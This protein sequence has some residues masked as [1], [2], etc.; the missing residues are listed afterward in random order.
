MILFLFLT[1]LS[2]C[3][4]GVKFVWRPHLSLSPEKF[5]P[6]SKITNC[7]QNSTIIYVCFSDV[8]LMSST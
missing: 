6:V 5:V 7:L 1:K 3:D 2:N 4:Y 8:R